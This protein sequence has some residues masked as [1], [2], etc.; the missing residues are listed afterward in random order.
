MRRL[1]ALLALAPIACGLAAQGPAADVVTVTPPA[2]VATEPV[3]SAGDAADDPA[4][5][6]HP[7]D[8]ARSLV[9]GTDKKGGLHTYTLDGRDRQVVSPGSRPNNVD[10]L[11]GFRL[12]GRPVD[13]AIASVGKGG[14]T[15]GVKVWTIDPVDGR[16]AE[17]GAGP[18][19]PTFDGGDPYG[20]C[21]YRS[22]R[23]G[24]AHVF[25]TDRDGAVEQY[26][27]DPPA[28]GDAAVKA[29]RVRAFRVG[30]QAEGIVADRERARLYVGEEKVAI[31]EYGAEPG[32]G[33]DRR[34]VA[35][36]GE[37]GL[38]A[39]IEG[40]AIYYAPAG[41][42]YLLAS[43]QGGSTI[44]VYE[45]SGDHAYVLTIDPRASGAIDDIAD[46]DGLD[47][48]DERTS[49]LFPRGLLVIQDGRNEGRQN[50]KL[51]AWEDLAGAGSSSTR[52]RQPARD[53]PAG[54]PGRKTRAPSRIFSRFRPF[55]LS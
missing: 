24:A 43:S 54:R 39:D 53:G 14:K 2:K 48:T 17:I 50:F 45:R 3:P 42:G 15:S 51:F 37:H 30:S 20:L 21:T 5:W 22:P 47:V 10:I 18:T 13:L 23:D 36:V 25:V 1:L 35:R 27:L 4:I 55:V 32:D 44:N 40:L 19:F 16:L 38:T 12:G 26:R 41:K 33:D 11:Y 6:I 49:P 31:W 8:P 7:G 9:L 28:G 34:A 52:R 29:T 46:S